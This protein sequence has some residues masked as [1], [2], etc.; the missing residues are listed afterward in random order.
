MRSRLAGVYTP[1]LRP[2]Q[3]RRVLRIARER[4]LGPQRRRHAEIRF[5]AHGM[6]TGS[7]LRRREERP[8]AEH[9]PQAQ[10]LDDRGGL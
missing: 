9:L 8:R 10:G 7:E 3:T 6:A 5:R 4:R 2:P 1:N